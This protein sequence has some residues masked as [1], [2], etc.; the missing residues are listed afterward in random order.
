MIVQF[1]NEKVSNHGSIPI[2]IDCNVVAFIVFEEGFHQP[3]K[4]PNNILSGSS[5]TAKDLRG[6]SFSSTRITPKPMAPWNR[7]GMGGGFYRSND[8]RQPCILHSAVVLDI[9]NVKG[10]DRIGQMSSYED[11]RR[12]IESMLRQIA[13]LR[14]TKRDSDKDIKLN[15][16]NCEESEK[17]ADV[18]DNIPVN[19]DIHI[20]RDGTDWI[21]HNSNVPGRFAP[22]TV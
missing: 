9:G 17:I 8:L 16:N 5:S 2:T 6:G 13:T 15:E 19:S 4:R 21:P 22:R 7:C 10:D 14:W 1:R 3:I 11:C 20:A 18:I 12:L